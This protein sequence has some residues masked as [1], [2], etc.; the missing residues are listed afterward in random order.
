MRCTVGAAGELLAILARESWFACTPPVVAHAIAGAAM[1]TALAS[2]GDPC[3]V[4]GAVLA[5]P[6]RIANTAAIDAHAVARAVVGAASTRDTRGPHVTRFTKAD[7]IVAY[8]VLVTILRACQHVRAVETSEAR[9]AS[10]YTVPTHA[11][12]GRCAVVWARRRADQR[13]AIIAPE[14]RCAKAHTGKA[15]SIAITHTRARHAVVAI[16]TTVPRVAK[17]AA[18]GTQALTRTAVRAR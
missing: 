8:S 1:S 16:E 2:L 4:L 13:R 11:V 15:Y 6:S 14:S 12:G 17:A 7:A 9:E 5:L 3:S 18:A 10:A